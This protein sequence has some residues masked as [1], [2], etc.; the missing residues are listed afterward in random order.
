[1]KDRLV[2]P[3]PDCVKCPWFTQANKIANDLKGFRYATI[4]CT[5]KNDG[6]ALVVALAAVGSKEKMQP[7]ILASLVCL[8]RQNHR[9]HLIERIK[10]NP[11]RI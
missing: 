11:V 7:M 10:V 6:N 5:P 1:M 9:Q 8:H 2:L 3:H 4:E